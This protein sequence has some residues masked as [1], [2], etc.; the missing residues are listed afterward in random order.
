MID[1]QDR[2]VIF[3]WEKQQYS[4]VHTSQDLRSYHVSYRWQWDRIEI[5]LYS[6]YQPL[7]ITMPYT[8]D[9]TL[10]EFHS[11]KKEITKELDY[12]LKKYTPNN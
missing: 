12:L 10:D 9:K 5:N 8:P 1:Q 3:D 4:E 7:I 11:M 6:R 2:F